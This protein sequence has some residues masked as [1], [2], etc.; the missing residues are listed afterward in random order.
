MLQAFWILGNLPAFESQ[1]SNTISIPRLLFHKMGFVMKGKWEISHWIMPFTAHSRSLLLFCLMGDYGAS[2]F[3]P[4][5]LN[6]LWPFSDFCFIFFLLLAALLWRDEWLE[7]IILLKHFS[8]K[9][10]KHSKVSLLLC[11]AIIIVCAQS[12]VMFHREAPDGAV[13]DGWQVEFER[14]IEAIMFSRS[15]GVDS[16]VWMKQHNV[17]TMLA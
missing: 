8:K 13:C 15:M 16:N 12:E 9:R 3:L 1:S 2:F 11:E 5:D 6:S 17:K 7:C 10:K 4:N 14:G